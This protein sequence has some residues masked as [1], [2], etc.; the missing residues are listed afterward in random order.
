MEMQEM[1]YVVFLSDGDFGLLG[2]LKHED[3]KKIFSDRYDAI[4]SIGEVKGRI[5]K[6][7]SGVRKRWDVGINSTGTH[8]ISLASVDLSPNHVIGFLKST[9]EKLS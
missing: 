5:G 4:I 6:A 3:A 8:D 7:V 9:L 1:S 2:K